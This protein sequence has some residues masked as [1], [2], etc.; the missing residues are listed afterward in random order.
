MPTVFN[1]V[2]PDNTISNDLNLA[3][4]MYCPNRNWTFTDGV[5]CVGRMAVD[6]NKDGL[7]SD[8]ATV[9]CALNQ[10]ENLAIDTNPNNFGHFVVQQYGT[11]Q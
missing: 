10:C 1:F 4:N 9:S 11:C 3:F 8:S 7:F 6:L 5:P 2:R